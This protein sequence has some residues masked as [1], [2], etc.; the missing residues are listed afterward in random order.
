MSSTYTTDITI[1]SSSSDHLVHQED[2]TL[3]ATA[4]RRRRR[5]RTV[6]A[7]TDGACRANGQS[8]A[9]GGIGVWF[10]NLNRDSHLV[11]KVDGDEVI[12]L[13]GNKKKTHIKNILIHQV[14]HHMQLAE[15]LPGNHQTNQRAELWA[16]IRCLQTSPLHMPLLII[17]DS[18]YLT[19]AMNVRRFGWKKETFETLPNGD[20]FQV[21]INWFDERQKHAHQE[22]DDDDNEMK[23]DL[24]VLRVDNNDEISTNV[25]NE[26]SS[27]SIVATNAVTIPKQSTR[28]VFAKRESILAHLIPQPLTPWTQFMHVNGHHGVLGNELADRLANYGVDKAILQRDSK[29]NPSLS[30]V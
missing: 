19:E 3:G 9:I 24:D 23:S 10:S 13:K 30:S 28:N 12:T 14:V 18:K 1:A 5:R 25:N 11:A 21:L 16:A 2:T 7:Y 27:S 26:H 8:H 20:L 17:S 22:R 15:V 6:I 4:S 29:S